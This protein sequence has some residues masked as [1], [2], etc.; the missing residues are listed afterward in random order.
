M[1]IQVPQLLFQLINFSVVL[2]A[3]V[4]LLYKPVQKIL[5]ERAERVAESVKEAE[6]VMA[7]KEKLASLKAKTKR[8]AEKEAA[9]ILEDA[10]KLAAKRRQELTEETKAALEKEMAKAQARW[11]EEK[12]Q[13]TAGARKE[14]VKAVVEV[15]SLVMGKKLDAKTNEKLIADGLSQALRSL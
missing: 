13:L 1:D 7:E 2:G 3:L 10:K 14:M 12:Q 6:V 8:D 15:S 4:Y 9:R 11:A 5:D